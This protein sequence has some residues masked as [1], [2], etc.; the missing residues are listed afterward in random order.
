[1]GQCECIHTPA[2]EV[3]QRPRARGATPETRLDSRRVA[4]GMECTSGSA[5]GNSGTLASY[6]PPGPGRPGRRDNVQMNEG[7]RWAWGVLLPGHDAIEP[8]QP[9][10][11]PRTGH[12][13]RTFLIGDCFCLTLPRCRT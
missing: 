1:M 12:V 4:R 3:P 8:D 2:H 7:I 6:P 10:F 13:E 9:S 11:V 5:T